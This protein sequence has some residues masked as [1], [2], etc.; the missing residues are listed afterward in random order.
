MVIAFFHAHYIRW[1]SV[2]HQCSLETIHQAGRETVYEHRIT[3]FGDVN[4]CESC[5]TNRVGNYIL[6]SRYELLSRLQTSNDE[7]AVFLSQDADPE[8]ATYKNGLAS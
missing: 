1:Y 4:Q 3:V 5:L 7:V 8:I 2:V 6:C